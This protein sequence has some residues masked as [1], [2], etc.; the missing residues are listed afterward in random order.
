MTIP[1][2]PLPIADA[3][4]ALEQERDRWKLQSDDWQEQA[5]KLGKQLDVVSDERDRLRKA[6][7]ATH[8]LVAE[9]AICGF[10]DQGWMERLYLNQ[11][12]IDRA[13]NPATP[14][15]EEPDNG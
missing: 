7:S 11:A 3:Y 15:T 12:H 14:H 1:S 13:L 5:W 2:I 6:L 4:Q 8:T 10:A 9:G